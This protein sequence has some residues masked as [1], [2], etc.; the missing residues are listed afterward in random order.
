MT[1]DLAL[2]Y[3]LINGMW[4]E[5]TLSLNFKRLQVFYVLSFLYFCILSS[6]P[7]LALWLQ[8]EDKEIH[9]EEPSLLTI[10]RAAIDGSRV[11]QLRTIRSAKTPANLQ[12]CD[13]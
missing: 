13:I 12:T 9:G 10:N 6:I 7:Q 5:V 2:R 4:A 1:L 8:R 3:A 11:A